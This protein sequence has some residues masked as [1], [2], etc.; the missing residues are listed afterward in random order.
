MD[1]VC[2]SLNVLSCI[3]ILQ[4]SFFA[5]VC[6]IA[7]QLT[8]EFADVMEQPPPRLMATSMLSAASKFN[9]QAHLLGSHR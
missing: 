1:I 5:H 8:C 7:R 2:T 6:P 4:L 3:P 9:S